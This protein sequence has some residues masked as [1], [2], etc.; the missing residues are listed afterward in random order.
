[1]FCLFFIYVSLKVQIFLYTEQYLVLK[2]HLTC[3]YRVDITAAS[4]MDTV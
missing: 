2:I 1:M 4:A 3:I